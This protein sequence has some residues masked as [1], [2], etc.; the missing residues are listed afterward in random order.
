MLTRTLV[1]IVLLPIGLA[2]IYFGGWIFTAIVAIILLI[3]SYEYVM[4]FRQGNY[5]P[6]LLIVTISTLAFVLGRALNGFNSSPWIISLLIL[7]SMG[8]HLFDYERG[9]DE[10]GTD[11][12]ITISGAL[13]IGWLGGYLISLR[14]IQNGMWWILLTLSAVWFAD[15]GAYLI[16]KSIGKHPISPRLSPKKTLEGYIGGIL[17]GTIGGILL[18]LLIQ[19]LSKDNTG[20]TPLHGLILGLIISVLSILGDL[21]ESMIKRQ[22]GQKDSGTI[23]PGHG[24]AFDRIDSWLWAGVI[25]YY[26]ITTFFI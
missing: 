20:I 23:L 6:A 26:L 8:Y 5:Q 18:V 19:F 15:A 22:V 17:F 11:F 3:A 2:A 16:G 10:A 14:E 7:V 13:Y 12:A 1:V 24:G 25:G 21:G 9:R 4:L